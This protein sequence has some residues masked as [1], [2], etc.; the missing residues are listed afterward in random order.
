VHDA[1]EHAVS[2]VNRMLLLGGGWHAKLR[3]VFPG[4]YLAGPTASRADRA[5]RTAP[6]ACGRGRGVPILIGDAAVDRLQAGLVSS[7]HHMRGAGPP[8]NP[9][10]SGGTA[11]ARCDNRRLAPA[12]SNPAIQKGVAR[13]GRLGTSVV[14]P[15]IT[16]WRMQ[17]LAPVAAGGRGAAVPTQPSGWSRWTLAPRCPGRGGHTWGARLPRTLRPS[18]PPTLA[19]RP[20]PMGL[21]QAADF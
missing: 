21:L 13:L 19:P 2:R 4:T 5:R 16:R 14:W 15:A 10:A 6:L 17:G 11:F 20:R 7:D 9:L 3:R 18:P 12:V 1:L 8:H